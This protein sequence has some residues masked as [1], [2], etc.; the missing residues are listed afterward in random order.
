MNYSWL[1]QHMLACWVSLRGSYRNGP[2]GWCPWLLAGSVY[3][4]LGLAQAWPVLR[5]PWS[6]LPHDLGDPLL[7]T[8]ILWR[9]AWEI[10]LTRAWWDAPAFFP[11]RGVFGL[12]E[13]LLGLTPLSSPIQWLG[14]TPELAYNVIFLVSYPLAALATHLLVYRLTER[15]DVAALCGLAFGFSTLRTAHLAQLQLLWSWWMPLMLVGLHTYAAGNR[16]GL[17]LFAVAWL[18]QSLSAGYYL[19]FSSILAA[20]WVMWFMTTKGQRRRLLPLCGI[21]FVAALPLVPIWSGYRYSLDTLGLKRGVGEVETFSADVASVFAACPDLTLWGRI[22]PTFGPER[23]LFL[24]L[25]VTVLATA[26]AVGAWR[27]RA[28]APPLSAWRK[29]A[30]AVAGLLTCVGGSV[31]L[32]GAWAIKPIGLSVGRPHKPWSLALLAF[33]VAGLGS[34]RVREV[35]RQRSLTGFYAVMA[36]V[37][38]VLSLGPTPTFLN[39]RVAYKAPFSW[40]MGLPG[41]ENLRVP[42][43][44]GIVAFLCLIVVIG[45]GLVPMVERLGR[46]RTAVLFAAGAGLVIDGWGGPIPAFTAPG[47]H[48]LAI[49]A[50]RVDAV[51]ELP[52]GPPER[53]AAA[54]YRFKY[55]GIP[56]VNGYSGFAPPHYEVIRSALADGDGQGVLAL[57]TIGRLWVIIDRKAD[58]AERIEAWVRQAGGTLVDS[59]G[60]E[61]GFVLPRLPCPPVAVAERQLAVARLTAGNTDT[62]LSTLLDNNRRSVW[63]SGHPQQGGEY[64]VADLGAAQQVSSIVL[65]QGAYPPWYPRALR[66]E[67][68]TDGVS[69]THAWS[70]SPVVEATCGALLD[71]LRVPTRLP[72]AATARYIKVTQTGRAPKDWWALAGFAVMTSTVTGPPPL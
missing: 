2:H 44:F 14:G 65:E 30:L 39:A 70:G 32:V 22:L 50:R 24:G 68:S 8:W 40:L 31:L 69:W 4:A 21:W 61:T 53:D 58:E 16:L 37:F 43:R 17:A 9:N 48:A 1:K 5:A 19:I 52:L 46:Y 23:D 41:L 36:V 60:A 18:M 59:S 15:H 25:T 20:A 38:W 42:A 47:P 67:W 51:V 10:P 7:N 3:S 6:A 64:L 34:P 33:A 71:P 55:H 26:V 13:H 54:Q 57:R 66:V 63:M 35:V 11:A 72:L 27:T 49:D 29:V 56:V 28:Y 45:R 12:S 62:H